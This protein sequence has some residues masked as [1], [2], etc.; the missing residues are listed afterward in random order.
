[1]WLEGIEQEIEQVSGEGGY[2]TLDCDDA[3]TAPGAASTIPPRRKAKIQQHGNRQAPPHP[4]DENL[5]RILQLGASGGNRR[6]VII[7]V[8]KSETKMFRLKSIFGGQLRRRGFDNQA[9]EL[10]LQCAV[11]NR[12]IQ[13]C[14]PDSYK[15]EG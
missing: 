6:V 8:P 9:V 14:K 4:G 13:L 12:M 3:I 2:D 10:F 5:R 11:L 1:M 7:G 15:V